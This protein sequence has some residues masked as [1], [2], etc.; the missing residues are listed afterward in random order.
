MQIDMHFYATYA[1]ARLA[2][3]PPDTARIV[4]TADQFVDGAVEGDP[5]SLGA[6]AA[7]LPVV[8]SHAMLKRENLDRRDPWRVWVPFHF[9]PGGRGALAEERLVCLWGEPGNPAAD[10]V[11][12]LALAASGEVH[13]PHLLG[14]VAHV[15]QD[16]YAHYG[17][18]GIAH[19]NNR[20]IRQSLRTRNAGRLQSYVAGKLD[21]FFER[22]KGAVAEASM[23]GH[24]GAA[25]L[26]DRPYLRWELRYERPGNPDVGYLSAPHDNPATYLAACTRL[27]AVFRAFLAGAAEPAEGHAPFSPDAATEIIAI[28][29]AVGTA[30]ERC[31]RWRSGIE[32]G[33]LF[34][35]APE[36]MDLQYAAAGWDEGA[37]ADAP[38]AEATDAFPFARAARRYLDAVHGD[39]LPRLGILER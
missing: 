29:S 34:E 35:T 37:L 26:P 20:V 7:L 27:H 25:T 1:L 19:P 18:S 21:T 8:S 13:G 33:L 3:F 31:E 12:R 17:F 6:R 9:L 22:L 23:L 15:I 2:G 39:I 38:A 30:E 36:D 24:A 32:S 11:I 4:A 14:I 16:T 28:L 10:A 5:V